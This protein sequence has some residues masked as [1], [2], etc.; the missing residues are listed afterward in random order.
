MFSYKQKRRSRSISSGRQDSYYRY[1]SNSSYDDESPY[2][3]RTSDYQFRD[4][5]VHPYYRRQDGTRARIDREDFYKVYREHRL[6]IFP[7]SI[8]GLYVCVHLKI[9]IVLKWPF[10]TTMCKAETNFSSC[11]WRIYVAL[12]N[13]TLMYHVQT[14]TITCFEKLWFL[15]LLACSSFYFCGQV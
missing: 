5:R 12:H 9:C 7:V 10:S 13:L 8:L 6:T 11:W 15:S 1:R 14:Q 4:D 2:Q 3:N